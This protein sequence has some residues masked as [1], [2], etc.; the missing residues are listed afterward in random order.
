MEREGDILLENELDKLIKEG[1]KILEVGSGSC[2]FLH[3]NSPELFFKA[4]IKSLN[5]KG[6]L[7]IVDWKKG[8]DTGIRE[9]YYSLKEMED[10][11]NKFDFQI[12]KSIEKNYNFL[13]VG[14]HKKS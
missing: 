7:I 13:I 9:R 1:Y 11:F 3:L 14:K 6:Y 10:Y 5:D 8:V 2:S 4:A 12:Y